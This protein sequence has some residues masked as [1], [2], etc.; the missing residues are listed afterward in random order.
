M[1]QSRNMK[2]RDLRKRGKSKLVRVNDQLNSI[3]WDMFERNAS[4]NDVNTTRAVAVLDDALSLIQRAGALLNS[5]HV[6][7]DPNV[8]GDPGPKSFVGGRGDNAE[9][10]KGKAALSRSVS[11]V[12]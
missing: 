5:V 6:E 12:N 4:L 9:N 11:S 8:D 10:G 2:V 3:A 7:D 1:A